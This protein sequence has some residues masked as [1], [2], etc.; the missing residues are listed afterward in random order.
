MGN[1]MKNPI[2]SLNYFIENK[3]A[4]PGGY[5]MFAICAD[6]GILSHTSVVENQSQI[7]EATEN[8]G[9]NRQWQIVGVDINY[10]DENLICDHSGEKIESAYGE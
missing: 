1:K 7:R 9:T 8:P 5:P 10:E 6:G 3:Y 2:E 4:W